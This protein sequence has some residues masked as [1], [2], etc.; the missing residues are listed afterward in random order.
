VPEV[1]SRLAHA[2]EAERPGLEAELQADPLHGVYR[3][4]KGWGGSVVRYLPAYDRV[5]LAPAYWLWKR[6]GGNS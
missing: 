4:K 3:F 2:G 6:R 5:Y 1:V